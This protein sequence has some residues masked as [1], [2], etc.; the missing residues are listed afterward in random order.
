M[1]KPDTDNK[2]LKATIGSNRDNQPVFNTVSED[3][4]GGIVPD[5]N[6]DSYQDEYS[7]YDPEP[8]ADQFLIH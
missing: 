2:R 4:G 1:P 6:S 5:Y 8:N 7:K 3:K